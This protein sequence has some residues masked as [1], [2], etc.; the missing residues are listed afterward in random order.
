MT[1]I[2]VKLI[3]ELFTNATSPSEHAAL[4]EIKALRAR[5][6]ELEAELED[7]KSKSTKVKSSKSKE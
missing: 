4:N 3:D 6:A 1:N 2:H 7:K 5:V